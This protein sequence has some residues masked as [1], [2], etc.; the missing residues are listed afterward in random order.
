MSRGYPYTHEDYDYL[1]N[2]IMSGNQP[3][4][5]DLRKYDFNGDGVLNSSDYIILANK[6]KAGD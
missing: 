4:K 6:L 1:A 3:T 2:L 5:K